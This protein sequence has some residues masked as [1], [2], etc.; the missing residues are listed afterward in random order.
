MKV[1][2]EALYSKKYIFPKLKKVASLSSFIALN[3]NDENA[4]IILLWLFHLLLL[5]DQ[6]QTKLILIEH[7][8]IGYKK[9]NNY[10]NNLRMYLEFEHVFSL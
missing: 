2:Y 5:E 10:W 7:S 6:S 9:E 1:K 4:F 3:E 8:K